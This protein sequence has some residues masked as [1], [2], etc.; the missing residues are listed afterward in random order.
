LKILL[1]H[2][3]FNHKHLHPFWVVAKEGGITRAADKLDM[4]VQTVSAQVRDHAKGKACRP[5]ARH[6]HHIDMGFTTRAC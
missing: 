2:T 6:L 1:I 5:N 4:A 3:R